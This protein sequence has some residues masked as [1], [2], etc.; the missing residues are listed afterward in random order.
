MRVSLAEHAQASAANYHGSGGPG[1]GAGARGLGATRAV[2]LAALECS[3]AHW[4]RRLLQRSGGTG[5]DVG[6][7]KPTVPPCR[8]SFAVGRAARPSCSLAERT[9]SHNA[10]LHLGVVRGP[11]T[12]HAGTEPGAN[13]IWGRPVACT[14]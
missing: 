6:R 14:S 2:R 12:G 7:Q 10:V 5:A 1:P 9:P 13:L 8:P 4:S 3:R 11:A